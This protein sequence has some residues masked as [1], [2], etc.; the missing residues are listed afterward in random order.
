M[1][2][3]RLVIGSLIALVPFVFTTPV[4][5]ENKTGYVDATSGL[6]LRKGP[7]TTYEKLKLITHRTLVDILDEKPTDDF[8]TGCP[9]NLWFHVK[10]PAVEGYACSQYIIVNTPAAPGE[11]PTEPLTDMAR[12]TDEEFEAY[13]VKEGFPSSY[14]TKLKSLHKSHPN[15]V[16]K[17]IGAKYILHGS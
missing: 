3:N 12:M 8:S 7:G 2:K 13:L 10:T 15:W 5:A 1:K 16:F 11:T 4:H 17:A 9:T 14:I 6:Y